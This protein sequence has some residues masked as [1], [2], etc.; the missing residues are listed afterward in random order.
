[1]PGALCAVNLPPKKRAWGLENRGAARVV[2]KL[3]LAAGG[4][5]LG[6]YGGIVL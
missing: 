6:H 1:M 3:F 4:P 5:F 2:A